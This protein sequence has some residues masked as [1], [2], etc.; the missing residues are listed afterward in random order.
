MQ[1]AE[2]LYRGVGKEPVVL[3]ADIP[4][5][6]ANR[7]SA[8]LWREAVDLVLSGRATVAEVD[9]A[10]KYGPG[11]RWA[12][13]GPHLVCHLGG[14]EGGI[15]A[16]LERL[17]AIKE[18]ILRDLATWTEFPAETATVLRRG[19]GVF[20][21]KRV[22]GRSMNWPENATNCWRGFCGSCKAVMTREVAGR[23]RTGDDMNR[24]G[25]PGGSSP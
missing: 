23:I 17:S 7:L 6:I 4:G 1:E 22:H 18:H 8:A 10:A 3:R 13:M 20:A 16:H 5:Y 12:V 9:Q 15:V 11:L 24:P 21:K 14:G 2:R 25:F 19:L